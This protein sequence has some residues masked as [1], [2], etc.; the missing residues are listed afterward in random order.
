MAPARR[1]SQAIRSPRAPYLFGLVLACFLAGPL[2]APADA[3]PVP[4]PAVVF[5][6]GWSPRKLVN[7]LY[8]PIESALGDRRRMIQLA[9]LSMCLALFVIWW[10][11]T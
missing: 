3:M 6:D 9:T 7:K 4:T 10:R 1:T 2:P 8:S 5:A 11:R